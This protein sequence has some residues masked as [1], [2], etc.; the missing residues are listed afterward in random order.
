M[1]YFVLILVLLG[2]MACTFSE[3]T[4]Q[5]PNIIY[6]LADDLG[7]GDLSAFGQDQLKTPNIDRL[8]ADGMKFVNHY[9]GAP[10]CGPSRAVLM[11]GLH[12]GHCPIRGNK[13]IKEVGVAPL[14]PAIPTLP[15]ALKNGTDYVTSM[16]GRWHLGGELSDQTPFHRGFDYH[17][18]KLSADFPNKA[19]VM[20][21]VLWD[22][23]GVHK[24][25]EE[26]SSIN[27]EP[28]YE[29]GTHYNLSQKEQ[30]ER[31]VNMDA[32]VTDKA[33][34]FIKKPHTKP[35]FL[36]VAY[37]L[38]H[39]PL[40][41]HTQ[42]MPDSTDWPKEEQFF[43]S[44]VTAL[45]A[46]VGKITNAL[47]ESGIDRNTVVIFTSDNGAHK[48]GHDVEF[49]NSNGSFREYKRSFY[50]GGFRSPMIVRWPELVAPGTESKHISAFWDVVPTLCD[51]A[52]AQKP[53]FTDGISF[54]PALLGQDQPQ[55]KYLY[56]EFNENINHEKNQYK[57]AVR[58]GKW[59]GIYYI[60]EDKF[61]LYD[62]ENDEAESKDLTDLHPDKVKELRKAM[63]EAHLPSERFPLL[64]EERNK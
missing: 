32:L 44:M 21:D 11:T 17:F 12:T 58:K 39:A 20:I 42:Y 53:N 19:G 23:N 48:E 62:L 57:Q 35:F 43:A 46:Y 59:K 13:F 4:N 3:D 16:C 7:Y 9:A 34:S 64:K 5:R 41:E 61:E 37:S 1:R 55:H 30:L 28:M 36:Y 29:N 52:G 2:S 18:G 25:Y 38:V 24:S 51:I 15:E 60:D 40:E 6:I 63:Q 8:A 47:K 49:F 22:E 10:V 14:D 33:I 56:W 27:I 54:L 26:Y 45:D 31:P 50:E